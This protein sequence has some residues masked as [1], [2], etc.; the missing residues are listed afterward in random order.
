M[1][2][3]ID[4]ANIAV[5]VH[6]DTISGRATGE[7]AA[8]RLNLPATL[9]EDHRLVISV[10]SHVRVITPSFFIGLL[11]T[12]LRSYRTKDDAKAVV[13]LDGASDATTFNFDHA[14]STIVSPG[15]PFDKLRSSSKSSFFSRR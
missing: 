7:A 8:Q 1:P 6:R 3:K 11:S 5:D 9:D 4:L 2:M 10:P 13:A 15:T 14:L 12:V